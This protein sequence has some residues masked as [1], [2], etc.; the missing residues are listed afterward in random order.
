MKSLGEE[1]QGE[2]KEIEEAT[3][4]LSIDEDGVET[5]SYTVRPRGAHT[6]QLRLHE[7]EDKITT[8][9]PQDFKQIPELDYYPMSGNRHGVTFIINN[10]EFDHLER[11]E[12]TDRDEAN[13]VETW[14]YLGYHVEVRRNCKRD[15][16]MEI[17][18]DIDGFLETLNQNARDEERVDNDSFVCCLLTHGKRDGI[19]ASDDKSITTEEIEREIGKSKT[20]QSIPKLFFVQACRGTSPGA[21]IQSDNEYHPATNR[22]DF[23]YTF[24]TSPGDLSYRN[25][26]KGTW[27]VTALCKALCEFALCRTLQQLQHTIN[28][29]VPANP[30][31]KVTKVKCLSP[32]HT[33]VKEYTQQPSYAGSMRRCVHFFHSASPTQETEV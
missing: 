8:I 14:L 25:T 20:L 29:A 31:Y 28:L 22:S 24:S 3:T 1:E 10:K 21:E 18:K 15:Q 17:F 5:A 32:T 26:V 9:K 33:E 30:E 16:M 11:R 6:P 12:G 2:G 7:D 4:A 23:C 19:F 13:L 27:F